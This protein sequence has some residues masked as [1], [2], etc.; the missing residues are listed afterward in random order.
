MNKLKGVIAVIGLVV[1]YSAIVIAIIKGVQVAYDELQ[2]IDFDNPTKTQ[3][4]SIK[5]IENE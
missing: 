4:E 1:K 3:N 5:P 2:K